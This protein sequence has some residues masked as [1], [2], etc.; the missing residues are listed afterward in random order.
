MPALLSPPLTLPVFT[1]LRGVPGV[2]GPYG[3]VQL[4]RVA[5]EW[6]PVRVTT[7]DRSATIDFT[8]RTPFVRYGRGSTAITLTAAGVA[9]GS[10]ADPVP[11][12][13]ATTVPRLVRALRTEQGRLQSA[14]LLRSAL[15][16]A[17]PVAVARQD[18]PVPGSKAGRLLNRAAAQHGRSAMRCS[19]RTT[20]DTV[21]REVTTLVEQISTAEQQYQQCY[22]QQAGQSPCSLFP[23]AA[24]L[25]AAAMCAG[26][27]FVDM[28]TGL[29]EVVQTITEQVVREALVCVL[30]PP[31]GWPNPWS[32]IPPDDLLTGV[33]QPKDRFTP[34]E[35]ADAIKLV[36]SITG[37]LG[38]LGTAL[39]EGRWS[40]A[41]LSTPINVGDGPVVLPYGVRVR[42]TAD[43]ARQLTVQNV[44]GE[45]VGSWGAALGALAAL[46]PAFAAATGI[47]ATAAVA[48]AVAG[49]SA[50][51]LAAAALV[52]GFVI[53]ALIYG[54]A[55]VAQLT[56][57]EQIGSFADGVVDIEHPTFA[58]ALIKLATLT[59]VPAELVPPIV[60]G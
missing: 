56:V 58:L 47:P 26:Q 15:L 42:I 33:A 5:D 31:K 1:D 3:S 55:L 14:M 20:V 4:F 38:P 60:T 45:V 44:L 37:F 2:A 11:W 18:K 7:P 10:T 43:R 22:D 48:A 25:C 17:Y 27:V 35:L 59:L 39:L 34:T 30:E 21:V 57:H 9:F 23:P 51:V 36:K 16:S 41:Q 49:A 29:V 8:G 53:L 12:K 54:T 6:L 19:T 13:E 46:S 50:A 32:L 52:L 24:G 40:L 28:V